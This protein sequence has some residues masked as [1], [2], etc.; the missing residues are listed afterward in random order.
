LI[1][2]STVRGAQPIGDGEA[3]MMAGLGV[4]LPLGPLSASA[5]AEVPFVGDPFTWRGYL[6]GTLTF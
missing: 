5:G 4:R 6:R 1:D 3:R 2:S